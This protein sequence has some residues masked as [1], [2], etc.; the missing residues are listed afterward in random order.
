MATTPPKAALF[1]AKDALPAKTN[2]G[3]ANDSSASGWFEQDDEALLSQLLLGDDGPDDNLDAKLDALKGRLE[4]DLSR[5][6]GGE[7]GWWRSLLRGADSAGFACSTTSTPTNA[8]NNNGGGGGAALPKSFGTPEGKVHVR[9]LVDLLG[10]SEERAVKITLASLRSF[11]TADG[12][13][14]SGSGDSDKENDK[15]DEAG[16]E[17]ESRLRSLLGTKALFQRVLLRHR[18]QFLAR[19]RIVTESLRLEQEA[20]AASSS[21]A[22]ACKGFLDGLDATLMVNGQKRGLFHRLLRLA[23]GPPLPGMGAGEFPS[24]VDKLRGGGQE[25]VGLGGE[26]TLLAVRTEAAEALLVLLYDRV[27]GGAQR[28]DLFLA[29]EAGAAS[30]DCEFGTSSENGA[31]WSQGTNV[32]PR[33]TAMEED[34][35]SSAAMMCQF[36][37]RLDGLWALL[38]A[39]C[40]GLWRANGNGGDAE[41]VQQH[42]LFSGLNLAAAIEDEGATSGMGLSLQTD[43]NSASPD[44][45]AQRELEALCQKLRSLGETARDRRQ[46]AYGAFKGDQG[47]SNGSDDELWGVQSPESIALL[48]LGLLLRLAHTSNPSSEYLAKLGGWGQEC[49]QFANDDCGAFAYLHRVMEQM[50]IDPLKERRASP[51]DDTLVRELL[52]REDIE[53]AAGEQPLALTDGKMDEDDKDEGIVA[54]DAASVVYASIG[55]EILSATVRAFR[56]ALL[57]LQTRTSAVDN[58][59][60]LADLAAA[61]YRN[62]K[63]LCE[64]FW[65]D[66]ED[67]CQRGSAGVSEDSAISDEPMCYLLDASHTL[68]A[69][70]LA[71]LQENAGSSPQAIIHYIKPLS[72]FLHLIAS[73]CASSPMVQSVVTSDFLP[74]GLLARTVSVVAALANALAPLVSSPNSQVTSEERTTIRHATAA[75]QSISTLARLGGSEEREWLRRSLQG[76]AGPRVICSIASRVLPRHQ[77]ALEQECT[78][79]A[80]SALNLMVDLLD[81]ADVAFQMEACSCFSF[82]G[83]LSFGGGDERTSG[84][85]PFVAGGVESAVT[86]GAMS[87]L[88]CLAGKM[89]QW[90][91]DRSNSDTNLAHVE[92][93]GGGVMVGLDVLSTLVSSGEVTFP[94]S[95]VQ[96]ATVNAIV[97]SITATLVALKQLMYLHEDE[98]VRSLALAIRND[99]I[100]ALSSS[101]PLGQVVAFLA[102]APV[103][104]NLTKQASSSRALS[105][106][107][108]SAATAA[109]YEENKR[110]CSKYGAWGRFVTPRRASQRAAK[111]GA[112]SKAT[113][114]LAA[115]SSALEKEDAPPELF[116]VAVAALSLIHVWGEHAE[117]IADNY[118]AV[119][120]PG[121]NALLQSSPCTLL[122]SRASPSSLH[123]TTSQLAISNLGLISRYATVENAVA[124]GDTKAHAALL[125]SKVVKMCLR[126]ASDASDPSQVTAQGSAS[127]IRV[128]LGGES[129]T[130]NQVLLA[131][132]DKLLGDEDDSTAPGEAHFQ[133]KEELVHMG[134]L[135]LETVASSV[136]GQPDLARSIL[137]G[138]ENGKDWTLVDKMVAC[139]L[140]T[141]RLLN[142]HRDITGPADAKVLNLRCLLTSAVLKV[143]AELWK[144]CRLVASS[145]NSSKDDNSDSNTV[146]GCGIIVSHL[147]GASGA[148]GSTKAA[149]AANLIVELT[150]S[151]LLSTMKIMSH[152]ED[153][154]NQ[155]RI[156]LDL[157]T[158]S[159]E[160]VATEMVGRVQVDSP[161]GNVKF[162]QDLFESGPLE[163]WKV[164]LTSCD[165]PASA[166]SSWLSPF[167]SIIGRSNAPN[168]N[169]SSFLLSNPAD[170]EVSTSTWCSFG[171]ARRLVKALSPPSSN[172][173]AAAFTQC[174]SLQALAVGEAS[175]A[176]SWAAFFEV[177]TSNVI[178]TRSSKE[179]YGLANDLAEITL[180]ALSSLS[181]SKMIA[182]S[183][184]SS[185]GLSESDTRPVGELCSL[186]L[187]SLSVRAEFAEGQ[188]DNARSKRESV[189]GMIRSLHES[190]NKLFAMTQLGSDANTN[191][192]SACAIR[193]SLLTSALVLTSEFEGL[194][195]EGM[196]RKETVA[197]NDL[198]IGFT[199]LAVNALQ[200]LQAVQMGEGGTPVQGGFGAESSPGASDASQELLRSSLSLLSHL[201]PTSAAPS[202]TLGDYQ[203]Y[204]YGV[205]F[206]ACL[207]ER[208]AFQYLEYHLNAS[209]QVASLTYSAVHAGSATPSIAAI[210]NNAV[211]VVRAITTFIHTLTDA[212]SIVVDI[213]LLLV[214][215]RCYRWLVDSPLLRT[216]SQLWNSS[217]TIGHEATPGVTQHRGYYTTQVG[218][219]EGTSSRGKR[220]PSSHA[221]GAH[222]IWREVIGIFSSLLRSARCQAQVYAKVDEPILRQLNAVPGTV[223]DFVCT[224]HD[225]LFSC[226]S[227]MATE[228]RAQSSLT[229][230][231]SKSKSTSFSSIQSSSFAFTSNLLKEAADISSLFAELCNGAQ[232]NEFVRQCGGVSERVVETSLEVTKM[233]SSFLGAIGTARELFLALASA[234]GNLSNPAAMMDASPLLVDGIPTARH[235]AIVSAHFASSCLVLATAQDF[236]DSHAPTTGATETSGKDKSL[237]QSFQIQVNN[238]FIAEAEEVAGRCL[239]HALATLSNTHPASNSFVSFSSEEAARLDVSAVIIA[240]TTVAISSQAGAQHCQRYGPSGGGDVKYARA[241]GCDRSTHTIAVEYDSGVV[242]RH[243]PWASIVGLEDISKRKCFFSYLPA[244]KS[245]ADAGDQG[246][247]SLGH[248]ILALKWC[249]HVGISSLDPNAKHCPVSLAKCVAERTAI[250]ICTEMML[251][252]E[253]RDGSMRDDTTRKINMQL[254]DLFDYSSGGGSQ[255]SDKGLAA[256]IGEDL[257]EAVQRNLKRHLRAASMERDADRKMWEQNDAGWD[258]S[259]FWGG[260]SKRQGRRSP[261][262]IT[263]KSSADL[264]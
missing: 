72:N 220:R 182:E 175:F 185:Q 150:R 50:V 245:V 16:S 230:K 234:S 38:C 214:E 167:S 42:P 132:F 81:D 177:V 157:M 65:S 235:S 139:I 210:H 54:S 137:L 249:R 90:A 208:R 154:S 187:N 39:E 124:V 134:M 14:Q 147:T 29:L 33:R 153:A 236:A 118:V 113:V 160:I 55:R 192:E 88:N 219:P 145:K 159:L 79:L 238:K 114:D 174:S 32:L 225:E 105:R 59:G 240:G 22:N 126:H 264:S 253:L 239:Y 119:G 221:D 94:T 255:P 155:K 91:F 106:V 21:V 143:I 190:A 168:W 3:G 180:A 254:L 70:I 4:Q 75:L 172:T 121:Q 247:P 203:T 82:T 198:R 98:E 202:S 85:A 24:S 196:G 148:D 15:E 27:E 26:E 58:V 107:M 151:S 83:G 186:L 1:G 93:L 73:L 77:N 19:L 222:F 46:A 183:M 209:S 218:Q 199:D 241:I 80:S 184:L 97:S 232:K 130:M 51:G 252:D 7:D 9:A 243:V 166:A 25:T 111:K 71:E 193:Q 140:G 18:Q 109:Y 164:L 181:D 163:C 89:T 146:H 162:M 149:L 117:D 37:T 68:A 100:N 84:F 161:A 12:A 158:P 260:G 189:L 173:S 23:A 144:S 176:S 120:G 78:A 69:S 263:R 108:D 136:S 256:V 45:R 47:G 195:Q 34:E 17:Q 233:M 211:D 40:M 244:P 99:A 131:A 76:S 20:D 101:T 226:F 165:G 251:H 104:K 237:E 217:G 206:A 11:A 96:V 229:S 67:F 138:G 257:L 224:Y 142:D 227:S 188:G 204:T 156:Y 128:A 86:S 129:Q 5:I 123:H 125:A 95:K 207:K 36:K 197:Y 228:A 92:T 112:P 103:L 127:A 41:W 56:E 52:T 74:K 10:I 261:F 43:N 8:A 122:L 48:S 201:A 169:T 170:K 191:Q 213:L 116:D 102:T 30:P 87:I 66:W 53:L 212:G 63:M 133:G 231:G 135:M 178:A 2:N 200:S 258:T 13:S 246:K 171:T 262:R 194:P 64:S 115:N 110:D 57:S 179:A 216:C 49:T 6:S 44:Q 35:S 248:L 28:L 242:N 141:S 223:F 152:E 61:I 250:L 60:M 205:D 62:Q 31:Q 259:A 215:T